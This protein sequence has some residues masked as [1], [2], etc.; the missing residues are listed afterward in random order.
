MTFLPIGGL[1]ATYHL[2]GEPETTIE[3]M[4]MFFYIV[5]HPLFCKTTLGGGQGMTFPSS[6]Q[7][8]PNQPINQPTDQPHLRV[9]KLFRTMKVPPSM[10]SFRCKPR[11]LRAS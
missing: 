8:T 4:H 11:E 5:M 2:L 6:T 9:H 1:Y 10:I 7:P 3:Y